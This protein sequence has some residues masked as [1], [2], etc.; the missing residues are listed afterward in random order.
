MTYTSFNCLLILKVLSYQR[1]L[2]ENT[3]LSI[4]NHIALVTIEISTLFKISKTFLRNQKEMMKRKAMEMKIS[5]KSSKS[6]TVCK[7]HLFTILLLNFKTYTTILINKVLHHIKWKYYNQR[8]L[9]SLE[10]SI[11]IELK[12][13]KLS[14]ILLTRIPHCLLSRRI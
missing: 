1:L 13:S 8:S 2:L 14:L 7:I 10:R 11:L 12:V 5:N 9:I 3:K 6:N 4:L